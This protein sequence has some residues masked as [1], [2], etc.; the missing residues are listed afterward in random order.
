MSPWL[1]AKNR[2]VLWSW[3]LQAEAATTTAKASP[4]ARLTWRRPRNCVN[5]LSIKESKPVAESVKVLACERKIVVNTC[6]LLA[7]IYFVEVVCF[8]L[9]LAS[10]LLLCGV[11]CLLVRICEHS[12]SHVWIK[13]QLVFRPNN[14]QAQNK[15]LEKVH[16]YFRIYLLCNY[17]TKGVRS[18]LYIEAVC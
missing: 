3:I 5:L 2:P 14:F 18:E 15:P 8:H 10:F 7:C 4:Q 13:G 16:I 11:F 12:L 1:S 9:S 6:M 17:T